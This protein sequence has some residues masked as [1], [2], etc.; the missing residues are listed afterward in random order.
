LFSAG[1]TLFLQ[2][3]STGVCTVTAG[4]A[5]VST[6]GSLAIPQNGSGVLY[7]TSAGVSIFYPSAGAAT[8]PGLVC[9]KAETSFSA[10]ASFTFDSV[11]TSTYTNYLIK[12]IYVTSTTSSPNIK[13]RVGG[14]SASTAYNQNRLYGQSSSVGNEIATSQTS[15]LLLIHS[16]SGQGAANIDIFQPF[17]AAKTVLIAEDN[18]SDAAFNDKIN[19]THTTATA[20]DGM[21]F[22][23]ASGT[24]TGSYTV[25]GYSKAV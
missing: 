22:F 15:G 25:Y 7:F 3:I 11:F 12:L 16:A 8:T 10:V 17:V 19:V 4:T 23:V 9:V 1:D 14:V 21:E 24:M 13:M 5:T 20:Y 2:N 6:A 18:A